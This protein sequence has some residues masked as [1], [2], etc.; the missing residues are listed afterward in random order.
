MVILKLPICTFS[1]SS[2]DFKGRRYIKQ[3][4]DPIDEY[5]HEN[6]PFFAGLCNNCYV[7]GSLH[8]LKRYGGCHL[9]GYCSKAFA[10]TAMSVVLY[11]L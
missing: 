9:V 2:H 11:V 8:P 7:S 1:Y 5:Y 3:V 4:N 10:T 6:R